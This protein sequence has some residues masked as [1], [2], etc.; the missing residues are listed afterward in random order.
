MFLLAATT[1]LQASTTI[2]TLSGSGTVAATMP[3]TISGGGTNFGFAMTVNSFSGAGAGGFTASQLD[4]TSQASAFPNWAYNGNIFIPATSGPGTVT[5]TGNV[6][7]KSG[8]T[9]IV[10]IANLSIPSVTIG[11]S[12]STSNLNITS[13]SHTASA[14][15]IVSHV[16]CAAQKYSSTA[17]VAPQVTSFSSSYDSTVDSIDGVNGLVDFSGSGSVT[18]TSGGL[19]IPWRIRSRIGLFMALAS[20]AALAFLRRRRAARS[21]ALAPAA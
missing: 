9:K 2:E 10:H 14:S 4:T 21:L 16:N 5:I 12:F 11:S 19:A 13:T 15:N 8:S 18:T 6:D 17:S 20:L 3:G 7:V 1:A